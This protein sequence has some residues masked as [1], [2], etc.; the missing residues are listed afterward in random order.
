MLRP[1]G[2]E[3]WIE[4]GPVVSFH[5]F[6]YP[7]RM[8][9]IRLSDGSLFIWSP[10]AL[11]DVLRASVDALGPVRYLV[12]PNALHH[13][14][15]GEWMSA[16]PAARLFA[17]PRLRKKRKD[18]GFDGDLA[19]VPEPGWAADIDQVVVRGSFMLTEVVFFHHLSHTVLFADLIQNFPR[20]WF[21]GWR[22]FLA[23]RGG[24]VAPNPGTPSDWRNSFFN[25]RAARAAIGQI[26]AWPI[27][28][29]LIAHGD[30]PSGDG[31]ALVRRAFGWLLGHRG[32]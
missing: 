5:G 30:L 31:A 27:E 8:A 17:S 19:D 28:R 1:F 18:L 13:F 6:P 29:V 25:R 15:L 20:D 3:I 4:D 32:A 23:R 10:V 9:V 12:S 2:R 11:S 14:Y 7:T 26:L 21:K 16:Y 22:G 24:I